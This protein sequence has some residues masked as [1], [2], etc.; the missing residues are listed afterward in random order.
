[1][2]T[3]SV[4]MLVVFV[5][6]FTVAD[7]HAAV[8]RA[9]VYRKANSLMDE[10]RYKD[11]E[12]YLRGVIS[13]Q[14]DEALY[15]QLLGDALKRLGRLD[16]ALK[17]YDKAKRLGGENAELYK[18]IGTV[19]KW[20]KNFSASRE[21]YEK[22]L[23]LKPDDKEAASDLESLKLDR[24][25]QIRG[26]FGGW[27]ADYTQ[28]SYE[29]MLSYGG[30]DRLD[31]Y[32]G[33]SYSDQIY[34]TRDKFYAKGYYFYEP[35]SYLKFYFAYK[36]YDYPIDPA[37]KKPNPD[38]N[39]YDKVPT[40]EVEVAHWLTEDVRGTLIYEFYRPNF[41][42]D[43]DST[44]N[45]HKLTGELY[46]VTPLE[47]LKFKVIYAILRDPDPDKT[48]IKGRNGATV[49]DVTY[50]TQQLLGGAVEYDRDRW[51]AE[52][53]YLPNRDLDNSYEYSILTSIG[54]RFTPKLKGR[55][56]YVYDKYSNN[57][58]YA[59]KKAYVYMAS[60]FYK[61][62]EAVDLGVGVKK[63]DLP[64]TDETTGFVSVRYKT[65]LGF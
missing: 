51:S 24:G 31:L 40:F 10:G 53:K 5:L 54:Y 44:A 19:N 37:V 42:H 65:G 14:P 43:K 13:G 41:F 12:R 25:L 46:W 63:L 26:W 15:H 27:E 52:L 30:F 16:E 7:V 9:D 28:T 21:A 23:E 8:K 11:A 33:Y 4:V 34:Y 48:K 57:S 58:I 32:A 36:D 64:T 17:E 38:S 39:S 56:D 20:K 61:L 1:M 6:S 18:S 55:L 35:R 45:N 47:Y 3:I 29:A 49:T 59:N 60:G 62:N 22:A 2:R 50:Q